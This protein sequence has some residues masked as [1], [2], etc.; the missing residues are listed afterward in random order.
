MGTRPP[1]TPRGSRP[2]IIGRPR[3]QAAGLSGP[4]MPPRG[5]GRVLGWRAGVIA[6]RYGMSWRPR[7][8]DAEGATVED[9]RQQLAENPQVAVT[10]ATTEHFNLQTERA[11][12]IGEANGRASIFLGSVSA[13]LIA[14]GFATQGGDSTSRSCNARSWRPTTSPTW[15]RSK[16]ACWPSSAA[17]SR[18][19]HNSTGSSLDRTWTGCCAAWRSMSILRG[20]GLVFPCNVWGRFG[21]ATRRD[22]QHLGTRRQPTG[23]GP[24][25][26]PARDERPSPSRLPA[27]RMAVA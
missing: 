10:F 6:V 4:T 15:P 21:A 16:L 23:G 3:R 14:P 2:T 7:P 26:V 11:A 17:T 12:T 19:R 5:L 24:S 9:L 8:T 18:P 22:P 1:P 27:P 20:R 13:G 25:Q